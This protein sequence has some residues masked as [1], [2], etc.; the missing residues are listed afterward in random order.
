MGSIITTSE[1]MSPRKRS[2][3]NKIAFLTSMGEPFELRVGSSSLKLKSSLYNDA[4]HNKSLLDLKELNFINMV[5][6][7]VEKNEVHLQFLDQYFP[8]DVCYVDVNKKGCMGKTFDDVVEVDIDQAY[9]DT[10]FMMGV[11]TQEIRE[12]GLKHR[13]IVRL[14]ALGSLA[15]KVDIY[16]FDGKVLRRQP[17][18]ERSELTENI[19][20]SI[21]KRVSDV[22]IS[23]VRKLEGDYIFYWVDGIYMQNNKRSISKAMNTFLESGYQCKVVPINEITFEEKKFSVTDISGKQRPFYYPG[24]KNSITK[25]IESDRLKVLAAS[26]LKGK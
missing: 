21:C 25:M 2:I 9:W 1:Q 4:Y 6:H 20:Y 8:E 18:P 10:A 26:I 12:K 11:I 19:W 22:M 14:V 16:R 17:Q 5:R 13:K 24:K 3:K 15:K 7:H 23:A